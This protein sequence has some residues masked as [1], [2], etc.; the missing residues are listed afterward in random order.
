MSNEELVFF[1]A[2]ILLAAAVPQL[3]NARSS[4]SLP[5]GFA[6]AP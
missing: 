6:T 1:W 4:A 5:T 2:Q 3:T